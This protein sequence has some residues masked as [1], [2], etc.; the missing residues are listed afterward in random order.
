MNKKYLLPILLSMY[1][2]NA[3]AQTELPIVEDFSQTTTNVG[4]LPNDWS[5][6]PEPLV[7]SVANDVN[8]YGETDGVGAV[9]FNFYNSSGAS[10]LP[11]MVSL[12]NTSTNTLKLS[13][14][15]AAAVYHQGPAFLPQEYAQDRF[16]ILVSNDDGVTYQ[17]IKDYLIGDEGEL[18]TAGVKVNQIYFSPAADE[19]I[20]KT[21]TLPVG[22][23]RVMF[24]G[25]RPNATMY[26]N[27][28]YM[29]NVVIE[30]CETAMPIGLL[31]QYN[32]EYVTLS[33]LEVT[34]SNLTWYSDE[35]LTIE[36][37]L[38]TE[39]VE[40]TTYYVTSFENDCESAPLSILFDEDAAS[41]SDFEFSNLVIY[42]N[43]SSDIIYIV[44]VEGIDKVVLYD[45]TG[46]KIFTTDNNS[47]DISGLSDGLYLI[48]LFKGN[49]KKVEKVIKR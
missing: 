3:S 43:P 9:F 4:S 18:N 36:L 24:K 47:I 34:G 32:E 19:W 14:D 26:G 46:K 6:M 17:L 10:E 44:G 42:P 45:I 7:V 22:T 40:G 5:T 28:A 30:V 1:C 25:F 27:M 41:T 37:P 12:N 23:Q 20:T 16:Q 38:D 13:F 29:D 8:A 48:E 39:L 35:S 15:F 49:S 33:D 31:I 11:L 21:V 2:L